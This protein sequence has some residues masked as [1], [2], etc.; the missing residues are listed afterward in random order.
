[1]DGWVAQLEP[2]FESGSY[3]MVFGVLLCCGVGLPLPEEAIFLLAGYVIGKVHGSLA[4]MILAGVAG[5][6]AGDSVTYYIGR[7]LGP[8]LVEHPWMKKLGAPARHKQAQRLFEKHGNKTIFM[9]GFLAGVR[10]PTFFLSG[11]VGVPYAR[12]IVLDFLRALLTC[13]VSIWLGWHFGPDAE[14]YL[15]AYKDEF[16]MGVGALVVV[17]ALY[18]VVWAPKRVTKKE[19]AREEAA[20]RESQRKAGP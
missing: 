12:F 19:A 17:F 7:K 8:A 13:P 3:F 6:L 18:E 5:I 15:A 2:Y 1:M 11:C 14:A 10:A 4:L 20:A 16:W 9:A